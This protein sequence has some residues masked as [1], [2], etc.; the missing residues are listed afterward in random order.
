MLCTT[1]QLG[2]FYISVLSF[3]LTLFKEAPTIL[4]ALYERKFEEYHR[5]CSIYVANCKNYATYA[6]DYSKTDRFKRE[7]NVAFVI[8]SSLTLCEANPACPRIPV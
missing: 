8:K 1:F 7:I 5:K 6:N 4:A 3:H 2:D